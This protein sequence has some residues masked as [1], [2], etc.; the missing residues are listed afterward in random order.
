MS[1]G[2][3]RHGLRGGA[4]G[5]SPRK[6]SLSL[7][8][9]TDRSRIRVSLIPQFGILI[10]LQSKSANNVCKLLQFLWNFAPPD[11]LPGLR[12]WTPPWVFHPQTP[13]AT[14]PPP[15]WKFLEPLLIT[16]GYRTVARISWRFV[17]GNWFALVSVRVPLSFGRDNGRIPFIV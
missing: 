13:W 15:K 17:I 3:T 7:H 1:S 10:V 16:S 4:G 8:R 5:L 9:E 14:T 11:S 2:D 6:M 12:P